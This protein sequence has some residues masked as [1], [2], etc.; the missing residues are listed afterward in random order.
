MTAVRLVRDC[1]PL[2]KLLPFNTNDMNTRRIIN[3]A[4]RWVLNR[5]KYVK[6]MMEKYLQKMLQLDLVSIASFHVFFF[7]IRRTHFQPAVS[8]VNLI[9]LSGRKVHSNRTF[10]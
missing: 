5:E 9:S 7:N 1:P 8:E 10:V 2:S 6:S 3:V 4:P